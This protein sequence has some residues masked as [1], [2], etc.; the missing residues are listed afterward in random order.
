MID[1][2]KYE[3][4]N[5]D[6]FHVMTLPYES[7]SLGCVAANLPRN[8]RFFPQID[9]T[10]NVALEYYECKITDCFVVSISKLN[11]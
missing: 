2:N 9:K 8:E 3:L 5:E 1:R 6:L 10:L 7:F 4:L 11:V